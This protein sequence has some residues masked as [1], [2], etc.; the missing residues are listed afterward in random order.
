MCKRLKNKGE[1]FIKISNLGTPE[2]SVG[3]DCIH[4][5]TV[6]L[7]FFSIVNTFTE[8]Y[9]KKKPNS[10]RA[11]LANLMLESFEDRE[12]AIALG[13]EILEEIGTPQEIWKGLVSTMKKVAINQE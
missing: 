2:Y 7:L 1:F 5:K 12:K 9:F 3:Y 10:A 6:E 13:K 11:Y 8:F 4:S